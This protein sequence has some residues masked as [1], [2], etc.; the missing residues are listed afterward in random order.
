MRRTVAYIM[1]FSALVQQLAVA[2]ENLLQLPATSMETLVLY[3]DREIYGAGE[4]IH[5][6]ASYRAPGDLNGGSWSSV[7]YVELISWDG[8]KQASSK[9]LIKNDE[10]R[11]KLNIPDNIPSGGYYLRAYTKWMRNYSA[12]SYAYLPVKILNPYSQ[13]I[14]AGPLDG[15]GSLKAIE[16]RQEQ[17]NGEIRVLGL[18]DNYGTREDVEIEILLPEE[19][20]RGTYSLGIAKTRD[21]S[22][23]DYI[24]EQRILAD[25]E[26]GKLEFL[27]EID[28]LTLSGKIVNAESNEPVGQARLQL[29]SYAD[30]FLYAEVLS[31][32]D[33][34]FLYAF[35]YFKGNPELHIAGSSD[36]VDTYEILLASEF[37]NKPL[38]LPFIPLQIDTAEQSIVKEIL[39]N[40][41]LKERYAGNTESAD[42]GEN[43]FLPFYGKGA[44]VTYV[45][46]YIELANLR[47][48][49]YEIIP[50]VSV[51]N[52]G[53]GSYI[54]IQGPGCMD[55][56]PPLVLLDNIPVP[57]NEDLLNIP[58][59]RIERIEVLNR[60]YMVGN[61]RYSGIF[62][63]Y[64]S[65]KDMAGLTQ[66]GGRRFFNLRM[67][68]DPGLQYD[69]KTG[70]EDPALPIISNLL[71]RESGI[72]LSEEGT[73]K[74]SFSTPDTPGSYILTLRGSDQE[75]KG[76]V[77]HTAQVLVK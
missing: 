65:K 2:Q 49:V 45:R 52:N 13:E 36:S 24:W 47:E 73:L 28:G 26:S 48:F 55:I 60:G 9:V 23:A 51:R 11:G 57:N 77:L 64:S 15:E 12:S 53:Q 25:K 31:G 76:R 29:S 20:R 63:I 62:S 5:F 74:L 18:K 41:Q 16:R 54:T 14:L 19:L 22:S 67:L 10:A 32:E 34:T 33:G 6:H 38:S 68:D 40:S 69:Q 50:Q 42:M 46:D 39:L 30:P 3:A 7:L 27:P 1:F 56:Y 58:G 71:Y 70:P 17:L 8:N 59:N 44:S 72:P 35:P 4:Q 43:P 66:N 21:Q 37:C 61:T 75:I